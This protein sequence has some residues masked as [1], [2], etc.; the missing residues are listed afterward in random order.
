VA[1]N[2]CTGEVK[3]LIL[4]NMKSTSFQVFLDE[5]GEDLPEKTKLIT[6]GATAHR[7]LSL[8]V[9]EKL[10]IEILPAYSPQLNPIERFFQELRKELKN[11][12]FATY[13]EIETAVI[14]IV[15]PYFK[16]SEAIKKTNL[17]QLVG[18]NTFL[19]CFGIIWKRNL[20]FTIIRILIK[21]EKLF[22]RY[23]MIG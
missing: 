2:P 20:R 21:P 5:F 18:Y 4:P 11:N 14:E 23:W 9:G 16:A 17:L 19:I 8:R 22:C 7:S 13:Q 3:A 10:E 1:L 15:K 6:D 12:V